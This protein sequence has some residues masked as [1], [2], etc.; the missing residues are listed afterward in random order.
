MGPS[1]VV[2]SD[3]DSRIAE[4]GAGL[5]S[6][7]MWERREAT[8]L[9]LPDAAQAVREAMASGHFPVA[10]FDIGDNIGGGATGDETTI[11]NELLKQKARGW[12]SCSTIRAPSGGQSGRNRWHVRDG[13]RRTVSRRAQQPGKVEGK[14]RSLHAGRYIETEVRHGGQKILGHGASSVIEVDRFH[15]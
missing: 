8:R 6:D 14:V 15:S 2:V 13:S 7:M 4:K 11:L 10:L 12:V 1:V 3:G 5:L 9:A